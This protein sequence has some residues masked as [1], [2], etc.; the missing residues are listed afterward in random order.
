MIARTWHGL[1]PDN[2]FGDYHHYLLETGVKD[3]EATPGN[4]GY[5]Y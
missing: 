2:K 3:L 5:L 1:V 4:L